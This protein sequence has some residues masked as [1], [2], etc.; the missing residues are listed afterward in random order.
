MPSIITDLKRLCLVEGRILR[1]CP[2]DTL[3][4]AIEFNG[5]I[6]MT[7]Y[8]CRE[9]HICPIGKGACPGVCIF[10][11][12]FEDINLGI[13]V[14]DLE[15]EKI[16]FYN[17][18][19]E[20]LL[21]PQIAIAD[22][23]ALKH[24]LFET[25][26]SD[27]P[28]TTPISSSF[29]YHDKVI[30]YSVYPIAANRFLWVFIQDITEKMRLESVADAVNTMDN[31]GYVFSGIRHEIGNPINSAKMALSVLKDNFHTFSQDTVLE[32]VDR[33]LDEL[34]RVEF[35]LKSLRNINMYESPDL[36]HINLSQFLDNFISLVW[37]DFSNKGIC[38]NTD[39]HLK[40]KWAF[41]DP[42]ALQQVLL[43]IFTNAADALENRAPKTIE[44]STRLSHGFIWI[45]ITDSGCGIS[46]REVNNLFKPFFT[47]KPQ[48]TGLG[49]VICR[50]ML[51]RM[52]CTIEIT[53]EEN[54][55]TTVSISIPEGHSDS[56][57][58]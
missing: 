47:L 50:K 28:V 56:L 46:E 33:S 8:P 42:R 48:G 15:H 4:F 11:D 45:H 12:I 36:S 17:P 13:M 51:A 52:N 2:V 44:M 10:A 55:G 39:F 49:L 9:N 58:D 20:K 35:L 31:L 14:F 5:A 53:S 21:T 16:A 18:A 29:Q 30:G 43:N 34:R 37:S 6:T 7:L 54:I 24:V 19:A 23:P 25:L 1:C 57:L 40:A 22:Y 27:I 41:V 32:F 3:N 26:G 38:I